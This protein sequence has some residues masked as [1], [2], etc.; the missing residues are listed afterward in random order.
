MAVPPSSDAGA[1][2]NP[3]PVSGSPAATT[4]SPIDTQ[5]AECA[6]GQIAVTVSPIASIRTHGGVQ[7]EFT[8]V[9]GVSCRMIGYP[10]VDLLTMY[11]RPVHASRTVRGFM[12]GQPDTFPDPLP[13]I[14]KPGH[15]AHAILEGSSLQDDG[16]PCQSA[17]SILV[18][19]PDLTETH[20]LEATTYLCDIQ[21]HPV[22]P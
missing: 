10:G 15:P 22:G 3:T 4:T 21:I 11:G 8:S 6:N 7:L 20:T 2:G 19:P 12:G 14:V 1:G 13:V 16:R 9:G 18:T 17:K 5:I